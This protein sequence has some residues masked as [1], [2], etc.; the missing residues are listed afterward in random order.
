MTRRPIADR[1]KRVSRK[2]A[3]Q[4][5]AWIKLAVAKCKSGTENQRNPLTV[6]VNKFTRWECSQS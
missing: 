2:R 6:K 4:L 3:K 1:P 5:F